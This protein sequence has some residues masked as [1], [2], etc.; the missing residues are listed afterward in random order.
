[1]KTIGFMA[2]ENANQTVGTRDDLDNMAKNTEQLMASIDRG[3]KLVVVGICIVGSALLF[4]CGM[5]A[6]RE[7][8]IS[9]FNDA[10]I[11]R[12]TV[13]GPNGVEKPIYII[14]TGCEV[15][16]VTEFGTNRIYRITKCK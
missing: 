14:R 5:A 16:P 11:E 1:M 4:M 2:A 3:M 6:G 12:V 13:S 9:D 8:A 10:G 15:T 7:L